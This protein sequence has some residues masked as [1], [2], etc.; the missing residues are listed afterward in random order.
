MTEQKPDS[1]AGASRWRL[2]RLLSIRPQP[3][4]PPHPNN[5]SRVVHANWI[6]RAARRLIDLHEFWLT[7]K[8]AEIGITATSGF[9]IVPPE[10]WAGDCSR[11][12]I[13]T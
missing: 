5:C 11:T 3:I 9:A 4:W 8:A 13:S 12:R 7:T 1:A 6:G 10:G 2:R